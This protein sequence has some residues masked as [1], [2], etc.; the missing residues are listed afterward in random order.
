MQQC[1]STYSTVVYRYHHLVCRNMVRAVTFWYTK[2]LSTFENNEDLASPKI[3][4][5][6][7]KTTHINIAAILDGDRFFRWQLR[8][9]KG[10]L[11]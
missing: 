4:V 11:F 5:T 10:D 8:G 9:G 1:Y 7:Y 3:D 2:E 6:R